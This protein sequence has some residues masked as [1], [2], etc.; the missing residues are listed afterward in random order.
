MTTMNAEDVE[1]REQEIRALGFEPFRL[2][3]QGEVFAVGYVDPDAI[4]D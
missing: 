3:Y 2:I 1:Q 4:D